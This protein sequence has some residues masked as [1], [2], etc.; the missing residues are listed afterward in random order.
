MK[1]VI[2]FGEAL[3]DFVPTENGFPLS[4][5][6][7]FKRA[8]GGA[9]ANVA[10]AVAKLGGNSY[11]AGKVGDDSFGYFLASVFK[12]HGVHTDYLIFSME[13][14]TGLAFVSLKDD[15]ERDFLF[16][17]NPSADL[18]FSAEEVKH[19]WFEEGGIFHF[20]SNTLTSPVCKEATIKGVQ[21]AKKAG[22]LISFDPNIRL[23]L[24]HAAEEARNG[25]CSLLSAVDILKVSEEECQFLMETK[26]EREAANRL[27]GKG[28]SLVIVTK[29]REGATY[30]TK[31]ISGEIPIPCV[32]VVDTTGAGDAFVGG[33][34]YQLS[35]S[36]IN[37][38][39][40]DV[41][42]GDRD[43]LEF[44]IRFSNICGG[45]TV[46]GRGAIPSLPTIEEVYKLLTN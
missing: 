37:K 12:E 2:S 21:L 22:L 43:R 39:N 8:P 7:K 9:P 36:D 18:L 35:L 19:S 40:I 17:R 26:D 46:T 6:E 10:V 20:G 27:L 11:F 5:V 41:L 33:L 30:Y 29:G 38:R 3:I 31:E 42:L 34:L 1:K 32:E 24:W 13:A 45:I 16:Y 4:Q 44:M 23:S 28:V 25:I 15:G 14:K